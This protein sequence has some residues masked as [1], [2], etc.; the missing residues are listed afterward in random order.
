M[1]K[2][3]GKGTASAVNHHQHRQVAQA[4]SRSCTRWQAEHEVGLKVLPGLEMRHPGAVNV[5]CN[6]DATT[7]D[8]SAAHNREM[9][10]TT[11]VFIMKSA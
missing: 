4:I 9:T 10:A 6:A 8:R 7:A 1:L 5:R 11:S 3:E 2:L